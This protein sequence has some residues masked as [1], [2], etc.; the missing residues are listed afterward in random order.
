MASTLGG[1]SGALVRTAYYEVPEAQHVADVAHQTPGKVD[2]PGF[3]E[4][5]T[6]PPN[7]APITDD[8]YIADGLFEVDYLSQGEGYVLDR[9]PA[10]HAHA[11]NHSLD[12]GSAEAQH[13]IRG[14]EMRGPGETYQRQVWKDFGPEASSLSDEVLRRGINADPIN[15]PPLAMYDVGDGPQGFRYG[16]QESATRGR[17]RK[18]LAREARSEHGA[19]AVYPNTVYVPP[20]SADDRNVPQCRSYARNLQQMEKRPMLVRTPPPIG[21]IVADDGGGSPA[22]DASIIGVF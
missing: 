10:D 7:A 15:N 21:D 19:R 1:Y 20:P 8:E 18:W 3:T 6:V 9:T 22:D 2:D 4:E 14:A 16:T 12:E 13:H 5:K 17:D 11:G